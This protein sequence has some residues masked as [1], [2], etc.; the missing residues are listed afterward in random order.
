MD[1][2]KQKQIENYRL[3]LT[4]KSILVIEPTSNNKDLHHREQKEGHNFDQ[5]HKGHTIVSLHHNYPLHMDPD[6]ITSSTFFLLETIRSLLSFN[7]SRH[8]L[9]FF[10]GIANMDN[11]TMS[12]ETRPYIFVLQ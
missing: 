2:N 8:T 4:K 5:V 6:T 11:L 1:S 10:H 12:S 7:I 9:D 3:H